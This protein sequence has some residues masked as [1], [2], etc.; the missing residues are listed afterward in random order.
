MFD[1]AVLSVGMRPARN[2]KTL[3]R[4]LGIGLNEYGF[5]ASSPRNPLLTTREGIYV[6]GASESP[7]DIPETVTQAS[8]AAC[9]AASIICEARGKDFVVQP[10]PEER[11]VPVTEEPRIGVFICH[12]GVNIGGGRQRARGEGICESLPNVVVA[13]ENLFTCSQDTQE[14]MK[15]VINE[16]SLNRVVVASCSPRTHEFLFRSTIREA[17]LNKYLF[18]MANIRDQ[19]SWVHMRDKEGATEKAKTLVRMAVTNANYI[20]PLKEVAIGVNKTALVV[21]GGLAGMTAALKFARQN[22][23]VFLVEKEAELGG[24]LRHIYTTL[25]G[26]DVQEFLANLTEQVTSH[27]LIHVLTETI[28]VDHSGFKGNFETGLLHGPDHGLDEA[29]TR[30]RRGRDRRRGAETLRPLR[31]RRGR[32][33]HDPDGAG[34]AARGKQRCPRRTG[35]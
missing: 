1:L 33:G 5:V 3:A 14:K 30:G 29:E 10:L 21:G 9:E 20:K 28:V 19:C 13:D 7:K 27:P 31:V 25:D 23:E 11:E 2:L 22:F 18:E 34:G 17:G 35:S 32:P 6:S 26:M 8:G 24:N 16:Y 15:H 12:C 4:V